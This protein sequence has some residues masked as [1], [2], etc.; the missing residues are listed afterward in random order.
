MS[1][2]AFLIWGVVVLS[3]APIATA[4]IQIL[5]F[6]E[7]IDHSQSAEFM[8]QASVFL[9]IAHLFGFPPVFGTILYLRLK[10]IGRRKS[11]VGLC[12]FLFIFIFIT[13]VTTPSILA[14]LY[15]DHIVQDSGAVTRFWAAS[16]EW[17]R[18]TD[19]QTSTPWTLKQIC[20]FILIT[21]PMHFLNQWGLFALLWFGTLDPRTP[22]KNGFTRFMKHGFQGKTVSKPSCKNSK[23]AVG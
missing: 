20:D 13:Y 3:S 14:T 19:P 5:A 21:T 6:S 1:R 17:A 10:E 15:D 18:Q 9:A 4:I 8:N 16:A 12:T 2:K 23:P 7:F 22:S 11:I